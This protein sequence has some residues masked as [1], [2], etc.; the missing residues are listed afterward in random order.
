MK[1]KHKI[2]FFGVTDKESLNKFFSV[3]K[4][5]FLLLHKDMGKSIFGLKTY[6]A[7]VGKPKIGSVWF[8][9]GMASSRSDGCGTLM[10]LNLQY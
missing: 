1:W 6:V 10:L 3:L 2:K 5:K 8:F 4:W 7:H 9:L